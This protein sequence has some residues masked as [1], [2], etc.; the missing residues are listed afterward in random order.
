MHTPNT[1]NTPKINQIYS[2]I[3]NSFY[4]I[5]IYMYVL[6]ALT[7]NL[8]YKLSNPSTLDHISPYM[9]PNPLHHLCT[10]YHPIVPQPLHI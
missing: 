8:Y 4:C 7:T 9:Y 3:F 6:Y 1:P 2:Y 5:C 10:S